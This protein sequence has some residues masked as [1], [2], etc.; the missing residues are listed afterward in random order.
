M[1]H[2]AASSEWVEC[3]LLRFVASSPILKRDDETR[4]Q[5]EQRS[6]PIPDDTVGST[7]HLVDTPSRVLTE[8]TSAS[9]FSPDHQPTVSALIER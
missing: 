4:V 8:K 3:L 6:L 1:L 2:E 9:R 5:P 7:I